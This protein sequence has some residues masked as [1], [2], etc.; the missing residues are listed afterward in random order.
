MDMVAVLESLIA[1]FLR[2][3]ALKFDAMIG[4]QLFQYGIEAL[5]R[6]GKQVTKMGDGGPIVTLRD[7]LIG[8][9][10]LLAL[11]LRL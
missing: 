5:T 4:A 9:L 1:H 8:R 7:A 3:G 6:P 10:K 2:L 11:G